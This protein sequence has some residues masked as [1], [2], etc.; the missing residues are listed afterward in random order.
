MKNFLPLISQSPLFADVSPDSLPA[1]L[2]CIHAYRKEFAKGEF[3]Y[4]P[5][6]TI[7]EL[8]LV[9][10]GSIILSNE[11]FFGNKNVLDKVLP[12]ELCGE[13]YAALNMTPQMSVQAGEDCEVLLIPIHKLTTV[14]TNACTNHAVLIQNLLKILAQR[15]QQLV[16]KFSHISKRTTREKLLSYLYLQSRLQGSNTFTIPFNRQEL[17]DYLFVERS[18]MS[19]ELSKLRDEGLLDY[20]RNSFKL[21]AAKDSDNLS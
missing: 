14:C 2:K 21:F 4:P 8:T 11:D 18:A 16:T 7:S 3:I 5:Q 1:M 10:K 6:S 20:H 17:A 13:A 9:L 12:G 19:H 15:N